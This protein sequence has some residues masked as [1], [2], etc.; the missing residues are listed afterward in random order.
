VTDGSGPGTYSSAADVFRDFGSVWLEIRVGAETLTPR[1]HVQSSAYALNATNL[2]GRPASAFIDTSASSQTK[3]GALTASLGLSGINDTGTT[4]Y[5]VQGRGTQAGAYFRDSTD[6]GEAEI[7]VG[8]FG[9]SARGNYVGGYFYDRNNTGSAFAGYGDYGLYA[10]GSAAGAY[11]YDN[12]GDWAYGGY[13]GSGVFTYGGTYGSFTQGGGYGSYALGGSIGSY[14]RGPTGGNFVSNAG[15]GSASIG[16]NDAGVLAYGSPG[17]EIE[18]PGQGS[19]ILATGDT[20]VYAEGRYPAS[21]GHFKDNFYTGEAWL[22]NGDAGVVGRGTWDGGEFSNPTTGSFAMLAPNNGTGSSSAGYFWHPSAPNGSFNLGVFAYVATASWSAS[23]SG[24]FTNGGKNFVQNDPHDPTRAIVYTALEAGEAGTYTRGSGRIDGGS[25]RVALDPTFALTTSPDIGLTAVLTPRG[26]WADLYVVS[27][28]TSELVV[29]T[30]DPQATG[31][32]FDYVI[33]GLRLGF[34]NAPTVIPKDQ[35]PNATVMPIEQARAQLAALPDDARASTPLARFSGQ[36]ADAIEAGPVDLT[37]T[38]ALITA[39]DAPEQAEHALRPPTPRVPAKDGAA[40][41]APAAEAPA[42]AVIAHVQSPERPSP[43][44][45][46]A[47]QPSAPAVLGFPATLGERADAG[48]V[49]SNDVQHPGVVVRTS[50]AADPQVVGILAAPAG[51]G[52][53]GTG[54]LAPAGSIVS[55]RVD[56]SLAPIAPGDLLVASATPGCAMRASENPKQGTVVAKAL[57][58]LSTGTGLIKVLAMAR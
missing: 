19:A 24:I 1:I 29:A 56:A 38:A 31:I 18:G 36:R 48:D 30:H 47:P 57:E 14:G 54:M 10:N 42:S 16:T 39:I 27:V 35:F 58:P 15:I 43:T 33:N 13:P 5:G 49:L 25:A 23:S 37:R 45:P 11:L 22:G 53:P 44:P 26:A 51:D 9:I 4:N 50:I 46:S 34:E 7:G 41:A 17:A 12:S 28:S 20:G 8:D 55:C 21:A 40:S 2:E 6:S 52:F 32:A 3:A